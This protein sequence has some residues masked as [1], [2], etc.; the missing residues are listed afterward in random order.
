MKGLVLLL[1]VLLIGVA[2]ARAATN[3]YS[4]GNINLP[5]GASFAKT[6]TVPQRGPVSFVRVSLRISTPDTSALAIS[7]VSPKGTEVPLV[8]NRGTGA[9]FGDGNGCTGTVTVLDADLRSNPVA[10]GQA[11]FTDNP[12]RPEG[13]LA[14]L[15][16]EEAHGKWTLEVT[17]SGRP[18]HL[19]CLTLDI[20]RAV[21]ETLRGH[22]GGVTATVTY[23]ERNFSYEKLRLKIVRSGHTA[24]DVPI[25]QAGC[26]DCQSFRPSLVRVRDLDGGEPE[27]LVDLYTQGAH[28]CSVT[29]ILRWDAVAHRYRSRLVFWGNYGMKL[30]DL[31]HDGLPELSA[32]DERFLYTYTAYVF[33]YAPPQIFD[34]RQGKLID[35]TRNFP[36]EI[37]KNAAYALKQFVHLKK[38]ATGFDPRAFVA[39]YVADQYLLGRPDLAKKALHDA[40]AK[41][42]LYQGKTYLGTPAGAAFVAQL[43]RNLRTWGYIT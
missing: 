42:I 28:C 41:G 11:P 38:A 15:Y 9:D 27:V 18:A 32:S 31:D 30:A 37:R 1:A 8:T 40:L 35:V 2:P 25:Q 17:N 29:L 14:S 3:T 43:N 7:L 5:I 34:Y 16:G 4:T 21:P 24:M 12:Y 26:K 6:L 23:T 36:G 39:V 19:E 13:N 22:S 20:A 33:S 10:S